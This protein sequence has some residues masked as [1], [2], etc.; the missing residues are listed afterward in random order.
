MAVLGLLFLACI[1]VGL[2]LACAAL[3][4]DL[5]AK[6]KPDGQPKER[7]TSD[8][9]DNLA[10]SE[11]FKQGLR[12]SPSWIGGRV[13]QCEAALTR[14]EALRKQYETIKPPKLRRAY[15]KWLDHYER[16][17]REN[18]ADIHTQKSRRDLDA[19]KQESAARR[20]RTQALREHLKRE[21]P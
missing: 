5:L 4:L 11:V 14:I 18:M 7:F 17:A 2:S 21:T 16:E 20:E 9:Y 3:I 1:S 10:L 12:T 13:A 15:M 8:D 19:Y 6:R